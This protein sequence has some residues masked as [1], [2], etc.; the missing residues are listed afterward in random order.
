MEKFAEKYLKEKINNI[1]KKDF[2]GKYTSFYKKNENLKTF[3]IN[4]KIETVINHMGFTISE[5]DYNKIKE[6]IYKDN[7]QIIKRQK[8]E[9]F[10]DTLILAFITASFIASS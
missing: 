1:T 9:G 6:N 10:V 4:Y 2:K 7:K 3:T 5:E 8:V